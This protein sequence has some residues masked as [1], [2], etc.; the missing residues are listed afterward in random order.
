MPSA[1]SVDIIT[2]NKNALHSLRRAA[3]IGAG[4]FSLILARA[5]YSQLR[6]FLIAELQETLKFQRVTLSPLGPGLR[7]A[8]VQQTAETQ[9]ELVLV[10]G[11]EQLSELSSSLKAANQE[12]HQWPHTFKYPLVLWVNDAEIQQLSQDAPD[13]QRLA[14]API[15]F[16]YPQAALR[17]ALQQELETLFGHFLDNAPVWPNAP[18]WPGDIGRPL[19]QAELPFALADLEKFASSIDEDLRASLLLAE[20]RQ[21]HRQRQKAARDRYER[22]LL[23]WRSQDTPSGQAKRAVLLFH[24]GLWWCSQAARKRATEVSSYQRSRDYFA[25]GLTLLR[26]LGQKSRMGRFIHVLAEVLQILEDWPALAEVAQE[27]KALHQS[28]PIRLARDYGYLARVELGD[29]APASAAAAQAYAQQA[30]QL[31]GPEDRSASETGVETAQHRSSYH[32]LLGR[33]LL[34]QGKTSVAQEQLELAQQQTNPADNRVLYRQILKLLRQLYVDQKDYRRAFELRREQQQVEYQLGQQAFIGASPLPALQPPSWNSGLDASPTLE[35]SAAGRQAEVEALVARLRSDHP[36]TVLHGLPGVGKST[37]LRAGLLPQLRTPPADSRRTLLPILIDWY[38]PWESAIAQALSQPKALENDTSTPQQRLQQ[39]AKQYDQIVLIFDQ[40]ED[41]FQQRLAQRLSFYQFLSDGLQKSYLKVLLSLRQDTLPQLLEWGRQIAV[42]PINSDVLSR[43]IRYELRPFQPDAAA[44]AIRQLTDQ[45]Q[46]YL[47]DDLISALIADLA[48]ANGQIH[49][50]TMQTIGTQLQRQGITTLSQYQQLGEAP[51]AILLQTFLKAAIQDC[52]PENATLAEAILYLLSEDAPPSCKTRSELEDALALAGI[53]ADELDLVLEILTQSGLLFI[54]SEPSG[55]RYQL[56]HGTLGDLL[57][58]QAG[59]AEVLPTQRRRQ[60]RP[61]AQLQSTLCE[62]AQ[63]LAQL[64]QSCQQ[65]K[66]AAVRAWA[67]AAQ[68]LMESGDGLGA[69]MAALQGAEQAASDTFVDAKQETETGAT[70]KLQISQALEQVLRGIHEKNRLVGHRG[71][72]HR[73]CCSPNGQLI[74]SASEDRMVKLWDRQGR[75]LQTL[76]GHREA[77]LDVCFSP[78]GEQLATASRDRTVRLWHRD[79]TLLHQ[80]NR[81]TDS[82]SSVHFNP[83]AALLVSG[84]RDRTVRLW[85]LEGKLLKTLEIQSEVQ[86]VRFSLDGR[87]LLAASTDGRLRLWNLLD[88]TVQTLK[89]HRGGISIAVFS[90]NSQLIASGGEDHR[91][92]LWQLDG[93]LLKTFE[94]GHDRV[95]DLCFSPDGQRLSTVSASRQ[96]TILDLDGGTQQTLRSPS[97]IS[98]LDWHPDGRHLVSAGED[99]V[100][101]L[102]DL[103]GLPPTRYERDRGPIHSICWHPRERL[104]CASED[105]TIRLW[106]TDGELLQTLGSHR[107]SIHSLSWSPDGQQLVSASADHT[108]RLWQRDGQLLRTFYGHHDAVWQV[109]FSPDGQLIASTGADGTVRLWQR[110]GTLVSHWTGHDG[111]V[112]DVAFD[113]SGQHLV[114]AGEDGTV[115][116][117]QLAQGLIRTIGGHDG[118]ACCAR[119]RPDGERIATARGDG[120]IRLWDLA[121]RERRQL[122]GHRDRVRRLCFSPNGQVLASASDDQTVRLWSRDGKSIQVI[123]RDRSPISDIDFDPLGERLAVASDNTIWIWNGCLESLIQQGRTWLRDYLAANS[124]R[125]AELLPERG[126]WESDGVIE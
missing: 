105:D 52:G 35:T 28:D 46:V 59:L 64:G 18:L 43:K 85:N 53:S 97:S 29:S 93:T 54:L 72:V 9:P 58:P 75:L 76:T 108:V 13:F 27:G 33:S 8:I 110:D 81:H 55:L 65:T 47:E 11:L 122:H 116:L 67:I 100:V 7:Q 32:A 112:W 45:A 104:I 82:V 20:G 57:P 17:S 86:S 74:A 15:R 113:P 77:V 50:L 101:R 94:V 111:T 99:P 61:E 66:I 5:N 126:E 24:L 91:V 63:T 87:R 123:Q 102:W 36:L 106:N 70:V 68:A 96:V 78:D 84:S 69:L 23:Y 98:S 21:A 73:V 12:R 40:F 31:S 115:R 2:Y 19:L 120:T 4:Q 103:V 34:L 95:R 88:K 10:T 62:Q 89:G 124:E 14:A 22:S 25:D 83:K 118:G 117:W 71:R 107:R 1:K 79:G 3:T 41:F 16:E 37:L 38:D 39:L 109:C 56:V 121:G 26:Q 119:F 114:S 44:A 30:L 60:P 92:R 6:Q 48:D 125:A 49:P 51:K 42:D 80:L 90:P